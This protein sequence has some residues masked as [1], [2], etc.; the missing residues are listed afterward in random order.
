[1]PTVLQ[2]RLAGL[3]AWAWLL[4]IGGGLTIGLVLR[5]RRNAGEDEGE[6]TGD[7]V[8]AE[9][10]VVG[11]YYQED[12]FGDS[13]LYGEEYLGTDQYYP[14]QAGSINVSVSAG[15]STVPCAESS[16]PTK[17]ARKGYQWGCKN[18]VWVLVPLKPRRKPKPGR[19]KVAA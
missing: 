12:E 14:D 10:D 6:L 8:A 7:E 19:N 1:M 4:V 3:P 2:K 9:G 13:Y 15:S 16:R 17:K 5:Y 11:E 18:G